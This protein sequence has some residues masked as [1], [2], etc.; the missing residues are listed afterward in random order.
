MPTEIKIVTYV[1]SVHDDA[2]EA[3]RCVAQLYYWIPATAKTAAHWE[4][5]SIIFRGPDKA[6]VRAKAQ[7]FWDDLVAKHEDQQRRAVER[8]AARA[9]KPKTKEAA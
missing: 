1:S 5:Q 2:P 3:H 7:A 4:A 8:E 6:T 9:S